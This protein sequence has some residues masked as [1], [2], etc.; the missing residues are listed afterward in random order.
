MKKVAQVSTAVLLV[1]AAEVPHRIWE[2]HEST[3]NQTARAEID[4]N[5]ATLTATAHN[6][7]RRAKAIEITL[8]RQYILPHPTKCLPAAGHPEFNSH[9]WLPGWFAGSISASDRKG[10]TAFHSAPC[11]QPV[12]ETVTRWT[13]LAKRVDRRPG[14]H[15]PKS[16][17]SRP[18][19]RLWIS[20]NLLTF[21][22]TRFTGTH[23]RTG[24]KDA[25]FW[26]PSY[27]LLGFLD[28]RWWKFHTWYIFPAR[29]RPFR[30]RQTVTPCRT[31]Y[32]GSAAI[33]PIPYKTIIRWACWLIPI[34][35]KYNKHLASRNQ[36]HRTS[37]QQFSFVRLC[38]SALT[39]TWWA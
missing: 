33:S 30:R 1:T 7:F 20:T 32:Y 15:I 10:A 27:F 14:T 3:V 39:C 23:A 13:S 11:H 24:F 21:V 5:I 18:K 28:R 19:T 29:L 26:F 34:G 6:L 38:Q 2:S 4:A 8:D 22:P 12:R 25:R 31:C 16:F 36:Q 35:S 9:N 37:Y 17:C